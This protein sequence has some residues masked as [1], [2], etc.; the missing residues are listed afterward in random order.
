MQ[1][2]VHRPT[3]P[4]PRL[5]PFPSLCAAQ[6]DLQEKE[7]QKQQA[8]DETRDRKTGLESVVALKRD[9]QARKQQELRNLRA[10]LERLD[11]SSGRLQEL[12]NEL[13]KHVSTSGAR[14]S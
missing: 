10:D 3:A 8:M 7:Q 9:L 12:E 4:A 13:A 1:S 11:G 6:A 5:N 2:G 14:K